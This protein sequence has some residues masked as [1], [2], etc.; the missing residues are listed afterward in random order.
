MASVWKKSASYL[1]EKQNENQ[2]KLIESIEQFIRVT[3][4][5]WAPENLIIHIDTDG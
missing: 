3:H 1:S 2:V 5:V 4:C